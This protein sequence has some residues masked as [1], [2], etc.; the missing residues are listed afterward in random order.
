MKILSTIFLLLEGL[1]SFS[2]STGQFQSLINAEKGF[3]KISREKSTKEAFSTSLSDSGLIFR[4][5]PVLGKKFWQEAEAG[6]DLLSWEPVFADISSSGDFGYTTG[7]WEFR[8]NRTDE[9]AA[10]GGYYV[11]VWKK[12]KG[13]WKVALDIG[14]SHPPATQKEA[15]SFLL[16]PVV[17]ASVTKSFEQLKNELL[18][19]EQQFINMQNEKG[20][21]A[22]PEFVTGNTRIYRPG[23]KPFVNEEQRRQLY[24]D[25]EKKFSFEKMNASVAS[26][27]DLGYVFGKGTVT[28]TQDGN[29][30]SLPA[31]YLRI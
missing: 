26:S 23:S 19:L 20:W 4:A 14:I 1:F 22:Y 27:G 9:L 25:K 17:V 13:E 29:A 6:T 2:Q 11:S 7:P 30:R 16:K 31:N 18:D 12:E 10:G 3:A 8:A 28:I 5:G 15:T 24:L 21:D